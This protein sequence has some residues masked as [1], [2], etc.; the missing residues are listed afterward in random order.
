MPESHGC[1]GMQR[2]RDDAKQKAVGS[3]GN[4]DYEEENQSWSSIMP[5]KKIV[6][7]SHKKKRFSQTEIRD[8]II[9]SILVLLVGIS[10]F[11]RPYGIL[12]AIQNIA[13]V[14][15]P[16]GL[17]WVP[18]ITATLFL[19][20]FIGHELAHKFIAQH[21]GMWSEFRMT[22]MGYYLS[23]FAILFSLPIFGTGVVYSS[24][25]GIT[26]QDG[27][28]KLA[29]PMFNLITAI[30]L[31]IIGIIVKGF[32]GSIDI[33]LLFII[34]NGIIINGFIALFNMIPIQPFDGANIRNWNNQVWIM[35]TISLVFLLV[36]GWVVLPI[37]A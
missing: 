7:R 25:T 5:K 4:L 26:E 10:A 27:K 23:L 20:A 9:A 32:I 1:P 15:L 37:I 13:N 3:F 16:L 30:I 18:F 35:T 22:M 36:V 12:A 28:T 31:T 21:Y 17:L 19:V 14:L 34:Q 29:G 8:L 24:G 33:Y 6:K 11:G 2:V